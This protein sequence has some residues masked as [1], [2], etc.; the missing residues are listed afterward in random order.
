MRIANKNKT[1]P[2]AGF[3]L[4]EIMVSLAI[5]SGIIFGTVALFGAITAAR[6]KTLS[7]QEVNANAQVAFEGMAYRIRGASSINNASSTFGVHPGILSL[8]TTEASKNPTVFQVSNGRIEIRE[9]SLP[10]EHITAAQTQITNLV[11]TQLLYP[12]SSG[13]VRIDLTLSYRNP[14]SDPNYEFSQSYQKTVFLN[15]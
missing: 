10:P 5:L 9:S 13:G 14:S 7:A 3:T 12:G 2:S 15:Q 11:F 8:A 6:A 1:Q 4:L